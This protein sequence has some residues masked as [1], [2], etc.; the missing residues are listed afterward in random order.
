MAGEGEIDLD[1]DEDD[2]GEDSSRQG[3]RLVWVVMSSSRVHGFT[4]QPVC[5]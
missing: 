2:A 4:T 1:E 5:V 3:K